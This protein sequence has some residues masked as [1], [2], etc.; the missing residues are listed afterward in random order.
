MPT[1]LSTESLEVWIVHCLEEGEYSLASLAIVV[2][3]DRL[4]LEKNKEV[5]GRN[6][7]TDIITMD[8]S[9]ERVIIGDLYL[10]HEIIKENAE[11]NR[12]SLLDEWLRVIAHGVLHSMGFNDVNSD[13]R[14]QMRQ[15]E[16]IWISEFYNVSRETLGL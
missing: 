3:D 10:N 2:L 9:V 14:I 11:S 16:S 5:F 7:R 15:Q 13:E 12:V 4:M 1:E 8:Y 6:Y